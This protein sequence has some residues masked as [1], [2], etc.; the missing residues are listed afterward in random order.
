MSKAGT[1][2]APCGALLGGSLLAGTLAVGGGAA[3][4][5]GTR[6]VRRRPRRAPARRRWRRRA[7]Q[8]ASTTGI[9]SKSV[10]VG[11]RLDHLGPGARAVRGCAD[12]GEGLLRHDQ[13]AGR[14]ERPQAA[15]STPRTTPSAGSRTRPRPRRRSASDFA[16]VGSF[17]LFDGYG[18]AALAS[19]TAVPDVSV[20]LDAGTNAL[21]NDFS[22]QPLS[23]AGDTRPDSVLQEALPQG[24]DRR[25]HRLGR[26]LGQDPDGPAVR[27]HEE[28]GLQDR[29]RR[30]RQPAAVR[31]HH[32][33]HQHEERRRERGRPDRHGLAGRGDLRRERGH[34]ELAPR[35]DLLGRTG[36]RRPVHLPRR[37]PGRHQRDPDRPGLRPLPRPGRR[38]RCRRS[39]SS[40]PTSRRSTPS[41]VPDLYTLFGWASAELFVQALK[42]A[43]P[44]PTR[45]AVM[46]QL[47]KITSFNAD[48]LFGGSDPAAKTLTP[49]FLWPASRTA[50]TSVSCRPAAGST[51]T[52][53]CTTRRGHGLTPASRSG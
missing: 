32:R 21:P 51:A 35:A 23:R 25:R 6:R 33:R 42:A 45:G 8:E 43:G 49:C 47:K 24:H 14:R 1:P 12:R 52:P 11:Q 18:C 19:D 10:T 30:R 13:R 7:A 50:S 41:W 40:T 5:H 46:A 4:R 16:L 26:R 17:S 34:A 22:A 27:R 44:N 48:G 29:L 37:G 53:S 38:Q 9:T 15:R 31:L 3:G 36:L 39:S 20:T 2:A 28:R